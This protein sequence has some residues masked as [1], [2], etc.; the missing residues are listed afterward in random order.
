LEFVL[1]YWPRD[2]L[3]VARGFFF[4]EAPQRGAVTGEIRLRRRMFGNPLV[5][6][7]LQKEDA[8][9]LQR[10]PASEHAEYRRG[11]K[12]AIQLAPY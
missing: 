5:T 9:Q 11:T 6:L 12:P 1:N 3:P 2:D 10:W 4:S 7:P 8:G